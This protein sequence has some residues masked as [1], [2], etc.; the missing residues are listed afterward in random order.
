MAASV[1]A[2]ADQHWAHRTEDRVDEVPP[3]TQDL[4]DLRLRCAQVRATE[5]EADVQSLHQDS[6]EKDAEIENVI[7]AFRI[8]TFQNLAAF[9]A[10]TILQRVYFR[11]LRAVTD[12]QRKP[13]SL[14]LRPS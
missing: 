14:P 11:A 1:H 3:S 13:S 6:Q 10:T 12:N 5:L 7:E 2:H 4:Q 9:K 8:I